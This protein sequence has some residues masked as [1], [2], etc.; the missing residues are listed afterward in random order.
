M[1]RSEIYS[2]K[3][4]VCFWNSPNYF[5][6]LTS[7]GPSKMAIMCHFLSLS[8]SLFIYLPHGDVTVSPSCVRGVYVCVFWTSIFIV[9]I[10]FSGISF[11]R[12]IT[13]PFLICPWNLFYPVCQYMAWVSL[14]SLSELSELALC[15]GT[16]DTVTRGLHVCWAPNS[17]GKSTLFSISKSTFYA[18]KW[19]TA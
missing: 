3:G 12:K 18:R 16:R 6:K 19:G 13:L 11:W 9:H 5:P 15:S 7:L 1:R 10:Q 8:F 4:L 17:Q 2:R 14:A